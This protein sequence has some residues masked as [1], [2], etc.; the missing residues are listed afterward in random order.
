MTSGG[1]CSPSQG[2][3]SCYG[4][5]ERGVTVTITVRYLQLS[6]EPPKCRYL[7][8]CTAVLSSIQMFLARHY[9]GPIKKPQTSTPSVA[10]GSTFGSHI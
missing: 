10:V 7:I 5:R 6:S 1:I 4:E 3:T 2:E 9:V 8:F